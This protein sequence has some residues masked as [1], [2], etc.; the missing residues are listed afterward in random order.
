MIPLVLSTGIGIGNSR[1]AAGVAVGG[2]ILY[3]LL[4]LL[5][6]PVAY[7]MFDDVRAKEG[8]EETVIGA[9]YFAIGWMGVVKGVAGRTLDRSVHA[10][11]ER[12]WIPRSR[13]AVTIRQRE[14][15]VS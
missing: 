4:T 2:Q 1:A 3:L 10:T 5:A 8:A 11:V 13:E 9:I 6:T 12:T 14:S 15:V 7:S